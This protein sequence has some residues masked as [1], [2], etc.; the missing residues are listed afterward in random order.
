VA[1]QLKAGGFDSTAFASSMAEAMEQALNVLL[2]QVDLPQVSTDDT[3]ET[4]D[5]RAMFLAIAQGVVN[6]LVANAGAFE[7]HHADDTP[8]S[9]K[10][11]IKKA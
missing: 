9:L 3:A 8:S 2:P 5:R 4:R 10:V 11:V 7:I 1:D 6:H